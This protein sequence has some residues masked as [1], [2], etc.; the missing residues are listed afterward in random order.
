MI[1]GSL[2]PMRCGVGDSM[3]ILAKEISSLGK[4]VGI[5]TSKEAS[6]LEG[7]DTINVMPSWSIKNLS[8]AVSEI[9]KWNPD[10]I[11]F[12]F[13]SLGYKSGFL[14]YFLCMYLTIYGFNVVQTWHEPPIKSPFARNTFEKLKRFI[15]S[16]RYIPNSP[17]SGNIIEVEKNA[18]KKVRSIYK[19]LL[20]KK[21][22]THIPVTSN[23]PISL[24]SKNSLIDIRNNYTQTKRI[25]SYFGFIFPHKGIDQIF[26][27]CDP[28]RDH[29]IL[30]TTFSEKDPYHQEL[31]RKIES[32]ESWKE[33]YSITGFLK[34]EKVADL[35]MASD[36]V[37]LPFRTQTSLRNGSVFA[38]ML[39]GT[40]ILTTSRDRSGYDS[41]LNTYFQ[42]P[43]DID[44]MKNVLNKI[45][46][47]ELAKKKSELLTWRDIAKKHV[48]LYNN[49]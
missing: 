47:K 12:Q 10:I 33:S 45:F 37:L 20:R 35:L 4:K 32:Y 26:E 48:E 30:I 6:S 14:P 46:K 27:I 24:A 31:K 38:A 13:P 9:K 16:L 39:Q 21:R 42:K 7:I 15:F 11:H 18:L 17:M 34:E 40:T 5:L 23:I 49:L 22:I 1:L 8:L 25:I 29:I 28:S 3:V 19:L 36:L 41:H 43:D 2:P 44:G